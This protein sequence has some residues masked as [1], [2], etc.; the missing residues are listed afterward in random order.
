MPTIAEL[1]EHYSARL[2]GDGQ[3]EVSS[4]ATLADANQH[5]LAF[6]ANPLYRAD[7]LASSAACIIVSESDYEYLSTHSDAGSK[8]AYLIHKN[9]YAVFARISQAFA[10]QAMPTAKAGIHPLAV[11]EEGAAISS[12]AYIGPFCHIASGAKVGDR[13]VLDSSISIGK[14]V[15][16]GDDVHLYPNVSIYYGCTIGHRSI[17]HSGAVI[18]SDGFGFAP[19]LAF[20]EWVKV[21]QLGAVEIGCDVEIGSNTS[22]DRGAMANTVIE[23]GCK[24]DNLVQIAH[25]V[26]VG[27]LTVIAGCAAI[28]GSTTIGKMC[29]IGGSA[30]FAGHLTIADRTT[31]SGGTNIFKSIDQPGQQFTSVYPMLPHADWEKN[32]AILRG[33]DKMRHRI[34]DLENQVKALTAEKK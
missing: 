26:R 18:G 13:A 4:V 34:R 10:K 17:I 15:T 27:A 23:D 2:A 30:N 33:L 3:L 16:I 8:R 24:I 19:D 5:Q 20:G 12:S 6:L 21:P 9:P 32:A 25:N 28:A 7:A 1:A 31:V 22:I 29:I 11:V 14:D